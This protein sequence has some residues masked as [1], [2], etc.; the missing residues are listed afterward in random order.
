MIISLNLSIGAANNAA[1]PSKAHE[2]VGAL[3]WL[4]VGTK[5]FV[6]WNCNA[7]A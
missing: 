2:F 5:F 4:L 3:G 6:R 7:R 1:I